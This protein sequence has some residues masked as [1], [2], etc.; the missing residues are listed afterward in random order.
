MMKNIAIGAAKKSANLKR[1]PAT[2]GI[3]DA[4][5][6][7]DTMYIH[8]STNKRNISAKPLYI[9]RD[10]ADFNCSSSPAERM[11]RKNPHVNMSIAAPYANTRKNATKSQTNHGSP[12]VYHIL[13]SDH[14]DTFIIVMSPAF[15]GSS[16][17]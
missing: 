7:L 4:R 8:A 9:S 2:P 11:S 6:P 17:S 15:A 5:L 14:H 3:L 10:R 13:V 1:T 16:T 12:A